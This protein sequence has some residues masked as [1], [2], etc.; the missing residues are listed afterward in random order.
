MQLSIQS[1]HFTAKP[2]LNDFVTE[3]VNKLERFNSKIESASISLRLDKDDKTE[4]KICEIRLAIPGNDIFS[5]HQCS[6]FEEAV[7]KTVDAL[8]SQLEKRTMV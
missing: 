1:L 6:T 8:Q 7:K 2:E 4:N 3:K 5:K